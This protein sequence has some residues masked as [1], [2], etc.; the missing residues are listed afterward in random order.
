MGFSQ[1][2][3]PKTNEW[4]QVMFDL[5][6][7]RQDSVMLYCDGILGCNTVFYCD[8]IL[9]RNA[10]FYCD[11]ILWCNA[12]FYCDGILWCNT[13]F[14]CDGILWCNAVFYCDGILWCN[15]VF[16]CDGILWC[17]TVFYCDGILGCNAVFYCDGI[18][19]RDAVF[20]FVYVY[21]CACLDRHA[22]KIY[23]TYILPRFL[24]W[25]QTNKLFGSRRWSGNCPF[26]RHSSQTLYSI[27][28]LAS[29]TT[30]NNGYMKVTH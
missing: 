21:V 5:I 29:C 17:N 27:T 19:G 25:R 1:L 3:E 23:M 4:W 28:C 6:S 11:G 9:W 22:Q 13:V 7:L 2:N 14:Y 20:N 12:V 24:F 8:G 15:A 26:H 18:L 16:Y 30:I 10:V